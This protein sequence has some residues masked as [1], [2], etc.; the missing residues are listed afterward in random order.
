M[1]DIEREISKFISY[2]GI[3]GNSIAYDGIPQSTA[4]CFAANPGAVSDYM[5]SDWTKAPNSYIFTGKNQ[6]GRDA[7][8]FYIPVKKSL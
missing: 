6:S 5:V 8:G 7:D 4:V 1:Q 3:F 2:T